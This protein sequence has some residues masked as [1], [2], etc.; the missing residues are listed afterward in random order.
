MQ[1]LNIERQKNYII[2]NY[3]IL[4]KEQKKEILTL[5]IRTLGKKS[6]I[7]HQ[8]KQLAIDL[9]SVPNHIIINIHKIIEREKNKL[10]EINCS[11]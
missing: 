3:N 4:S 6:L 1:E 11:N 7:V 8:N 5:I 9:D 2:D 10:S